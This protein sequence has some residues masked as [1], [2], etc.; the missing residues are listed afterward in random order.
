[1]LYWF[2]VYSKVIQSYI[3]ACIYVC[4]CIYVVLRFF[5]IIGYYKILCKVPYAIESLLVIYFIHSCVYSL[6]PNSQ[7]YPPFPFDNNKF[8]FYVCQSISIL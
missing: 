1:M 7:F 8:V 6:I 5:S 4:V 3:Y 2:Q